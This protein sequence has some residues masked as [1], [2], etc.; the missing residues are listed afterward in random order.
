MLMTWQAE[1]L[2]RQRLAEATGRVR[3]DDARATPARRTALVATLLT[4]LRLA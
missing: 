4:L 2:H 3:G 1:H